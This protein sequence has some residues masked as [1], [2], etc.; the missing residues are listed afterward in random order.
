MISF[1]DQRLTCFSGLFIF[2]V[3]FSRTKLKQYLKRYFS[4]LKVS[5]L[6]DRHLMEADNTYMGH[7]NTLIYVIEHDI[8]ATLDILHEHEKTGKWSDFL[9]G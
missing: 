6:F 2:Q 3:L 8:I 7:D 9:N 5:L 4:H 1:E